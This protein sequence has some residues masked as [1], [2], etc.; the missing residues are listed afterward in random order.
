MIFIML[1]YDNN[2]QISVNIQ[3]HQKLIV[4]F[5]SMVSSFDNSI[6]TYN[7]HEDS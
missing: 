6:K 3:V 2:V 4:S 7:L 5:T 1:L